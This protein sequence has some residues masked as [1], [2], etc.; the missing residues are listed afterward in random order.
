MIIK[1]VNFSIIQY[2]VFNLH[3]KYWATYSNEIAKDIWDKH[4]ERWVVNHIRHNYTNYDEY[5][6]GK[7]IIQ[8]RNII[9]NMITNAYPI[10]K[11]ECERQKE[12]PKW[13]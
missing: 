13:R 6:K 8:V 12:E 4:K 10:L 7:D 1:I 11:E 3:E 5:R 9:L 2:E